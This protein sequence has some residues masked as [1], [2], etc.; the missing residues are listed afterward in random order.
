MVPEEC[1][2]WLENYLAG[3]VVTVLQLRQE[4]LQFTEMLTSYGLDSLT[5]LEIKNR[6]TRDSGVVLSMVHLLQGMSIRDLA[7]ELAAHLHG[8][9]PAAQD[10]ILAREM[11][12]EEAGNHPDGTKLSTLTDLNQLSDQEVDHL[13]KKYWKEN[14]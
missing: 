5:A 8:M 11:K 9:Q 1:Q 4:N 6:V 10:I 14:E 13:L 12:R 2:S 3:V 7:A